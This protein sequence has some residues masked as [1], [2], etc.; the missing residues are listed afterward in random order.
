[1][2][3]LGVH[4]GYLMARDAQGRIYVG[5]TATRNRVGG[6]LG[7]YDPATGQVS[8]IGTPTLGNYEAQGLAATSD[9]RFIVYSSSVVADPLQPSATLSAAK[10]FVY[11]PSTKAFV[12]QW[13]PVPNRWSR[14]PVAP[15]AP[16]QVVGVAPNGSQT[17]IYAVDVLTGRVVYQR[18]VPGTQARDASFSVGPDGQ[19]WTFLENQLVRIRPETG[20][21]TPVGTV[22]SGAGH[23]AFV[24]RDI[25]LA[26][27]TTLRRIRGVVPQ[28]R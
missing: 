24:G 8:G 4:Y 2:Q 1:M 7:I 10:L 5:A 3:S 27:T 28:D 16:G 15:G 19:I 21:V 12:H 11:D 22:A 17:T 14:G 9:G 20:D 26:G 23:I 25:Y 6:A 18:D 13:A